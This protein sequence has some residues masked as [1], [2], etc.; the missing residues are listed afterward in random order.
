MISSIDLI[1]TFNDSASL[2]GGIQG[3][4]NLG[5]GAGGPSVSLSPTLGT[6][7]SGSQ[8]IYDVTF[9]GAPFNGLDPNNT[10]ALVLW[11]NNTSGIE[12]GLVSWSLDITALPEPVTVAL[13]VFAGVFLVVILAR[14]RRVQDRIRRWRAAAVRWPDA[15]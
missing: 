14:S 5:T 1:L 9:S 12:N 7:G 10:W 3:L 13:L 8:R 4:L 2:P 15:V 11:D 6:P